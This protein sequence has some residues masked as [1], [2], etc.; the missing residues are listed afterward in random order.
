MIMMVVSALLQ[1]AVSY[2]YLHIFT[3]VFNNWL[4]LL[5]INGVKQRWTHMTPTID[6][7]V[8][9]NWYKKQDIQKTD[10]TGDATAALR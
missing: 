4:D 7:T 2:I 6:Q 9:V 8:V 5:C 3:S 10:R 1:K